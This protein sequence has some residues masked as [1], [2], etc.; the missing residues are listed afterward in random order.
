M[1]QVGYLKTE[2]DEYGADGSGHIRIFANT[3]AVT[4]FLPEML[5]GYLGRNP[6]VTI[7][8]QERSSRDIVRGVLEGS[9]D[10]G[11]TAGTITAK[12]LEVIHFSTDRVVLVVPLGHPL[13][14]ADT[15][16][17]HQVGLQEGSTLHEFVREHAEQAGRNLS[18]RI[19]VSSFEALCRMV[20]AGVGIGIIPQS[21]ELRHQKTLQLS[22]VPLDEAWALRER[23]ILVRDFDALPG[24]VKALINL[25][26]PTADDSGK[27]PG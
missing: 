17:Y 18:W 16:E 27:Q 8:L 6:G 4:E 26:R 23:S 22:V 11:I 24:C 1:R 21:A 9:T 15:L 7:D 5:A 10:L 19:Q 13:R 12:D 14:L 25:M 20:E 3:T 2:F